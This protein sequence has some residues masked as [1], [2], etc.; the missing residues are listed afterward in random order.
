M[1]LEEVKNVWYT[2]TEY[3][4]RTQSQNGRGE[5]SDKNANS[6]TLDSD[7]K[8]SKLYFIEDDNSFN[9]VSI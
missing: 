4:F 8:T 5:G 7:N 3:N 1:I 2:L 9:E 6:G